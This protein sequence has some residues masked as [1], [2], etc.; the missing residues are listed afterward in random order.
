MSADFHQLE[1]PIVKE[2]SATDPPA[3]LK[4]TLWVSFFIFFAG[5]L[6]FG[7]TRGFESGLWFGVSAGMT[8]VNVMLGAWAV[9]FGLSRLKKAPLLLT[10]L[11][12]KSTTFV[13]VVAVILAFL[14]PLVLPFTTG[15]AVVIV[16]AVLTAVWEIR[17]LRS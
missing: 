3:V 8:L 2:V 6:G 17:R 14:K 7:L 12:M 4:I 1:S 15:F 9:R 13:M 5:T 11:L 10:V 16:G